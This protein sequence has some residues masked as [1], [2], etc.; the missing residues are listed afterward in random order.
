[1]GLA[2]AM[3]TSLGTGA[4][5]YLS[6]MQGYVG[7]AGGVL[8]F[9]TAYGLETLWEYRYYPQVQDLT[10]KLGYTVYAGLTL[11][12]GVYNN[13]VPLTIAAACIML[14]ISVSSLNSAARSFMAMRSMMTRIVM[15]KKNI[16]IITDY[17]DNN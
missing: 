6:N 2:T 7:I 4:G 8:G 10:K 16:E 11:C 17:L 5:L 12:I 14:A 9:A 15:M 3:G 1:M 13:S